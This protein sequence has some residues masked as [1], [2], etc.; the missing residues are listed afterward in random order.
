MAV[1][2]SVISLLFLVTTKSKKSKQ[3]LEGTILAYILIKAIS[4]V[5]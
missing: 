5:L 3:I 4:S 2:V 1:I